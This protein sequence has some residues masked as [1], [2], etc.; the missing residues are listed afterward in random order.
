MLRGGHGN[1]N[2]VRLERTMISK[3]GNLAGKETMP[4][5]ASRLLDRGEKL[6]ERLPPEPASGLQPNAA[7]ALL[8]HRTGVDELHA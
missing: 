3:R 6:I 8:T 1:R 7:T 4:Q 5:E 2:R